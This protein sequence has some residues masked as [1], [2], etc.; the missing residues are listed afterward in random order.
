MAQ[1]KLFPNWSW[2]RGLPE[3]FNDTAV[4]SPRTDATSKYN[5]MSSPKATLHAATLRGIL[6]YMEI[7]SSIGTPTPGAKGAVGTQSEEIIVTEYPSSSGAIHAVNFNKN[8]GKFTVG[9]FTDPTA[10]PE[11]YTLKDSAESGAALFFTLMLSALEDDEFSEQYNLLAEER[12]KGYP[13]KDKLSQIGCVL[14]DNLYRRLESAPHLGAAGIPVSV[15]SGGNLQ[16]LS[17]LNLNKGV[18]NPAN[19]IYGDFEVLQVGAVAKTAMAAT[20]HEDF[21]G[22]Y[23]L[24]SRKF[25]GSE[26][27]LIPSLPSWY[28]IPPEV[29]QIC[30]YSLKTSGTEAPMRNFMLRGPAGTGKTEGVRAVAAGLGLPYVFLTCAADFD[31]F[32]FIGQFVPATTPSSGLDASQ[33]ELPTFDD[34]RMD[35][36]TAYS[37]L[38]GVYNEDITEDE[39]YQMLLQKIGEQAAA[40]AVGSEKK[41]TGFRYVDTP[42]IQA[43]RNGWVI[44]LQEPSIIANQ[45]VLV[46]LNG[47]LDNSKAI[48]LPTGE[49]IRRHP[50]TVVIISTNTDYVG[51]RAMNQSV[52]SRMDLI[53]DMNEPEKDELVRRVSGITSCSNLSVLSQMAEAIGDIQMKCRSEAITDGCCGMRELISWVQSYMICGNVMEAATHT[54][55]SSVSSNVDNR[56]EISRTCLETR[57][58]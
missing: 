36:C 37:K 13:D 52:L 17:P 54:V 51:C 27:M 7:D 9:C 8:N 18:Y 46:G 40:A 11:V 38:T 58:A 35:P 3:P 2:G 48:M 28:V 31:K 30:N 10:T 24:S 56:D 41:E 53:I 39:V 44:E 45:G 22:K 1:S 32:D 29:V 57:F 21:L 25:S 42:F 12:Q 49:V 19:V 33:V 34:I 50:D 20:K 4:T 6:A 15:P 43:L 5:S 26:S 55:L 16:R 23:A 47:L 14:C